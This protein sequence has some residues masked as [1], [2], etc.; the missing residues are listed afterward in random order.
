MHKI[1]KIKYVSVAFLLCLSL[2][3]NAQ[4][5]YATYDAYVEQYKDLAIEQM[6]EHKIPASITLAQGLLE[7]GAGK[8]SLAVRANNH[9]GIKCHTSWLG[10]R[11]YK[12]DDAKNECFRVYKSV[13]ESYEDH[14]LFLLRDRYARL[15]SYDIYD[16]KAWAKGLKACGYATS[17]SY[18]D[19]LIKIIETYELYRYDRGESVA[20]NKHKTDNAPAPRQFVNHNHQ[21]YLVNDIVCYRAQQGDDWDNLSYELGISKKKL[22]KYNECEDTYTQIAGMNIFAAKKRSKAD[23]NL[24]G[25][26]HKVRRGDSMYT[27]SQLYGIRIKKLYKMNHKGADYVPVEGD[28]IKVK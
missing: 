15:F 18:A 23:S 9:F 5:R 13:R 10:E 21:P 17:P 22:L 27:I 28:L 8:S 1:D 2:S 6:R 4:Q 20:S 7:S 14:S 16:Y 25:N 26:W 12:D 24:S 3:A 19:R 11:I